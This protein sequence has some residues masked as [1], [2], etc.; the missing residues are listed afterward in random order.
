MWLFL[1]IA[2]HKQILQMCV[3]LLLG[4]FQLPKL[5]QIECIDDAERDIGDSSNSIWLFS[6]N[7]PAKNYS[8]NG[9]LC[10][11]TIFRQE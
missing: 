10:F 8:G 4:L 7:N 1:E 9:G 5:F 3:C 6:R 2:F 11:P